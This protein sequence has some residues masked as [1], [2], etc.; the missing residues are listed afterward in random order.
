MDRGVANVHPGQPRQLRRLVVEV[1]VRRQQGDLLQRDQVRVELGDD[2][3]DPRQAVAV[4]VPPPGRR[5][6]LTRTDR[7]PDV[8]CRDP[9][10]RRAAAHPQ[11]CAAT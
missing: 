11:A 9:D 10:G 2:P 3:G 1:A 5:E 8:P 7:G 4:D 6:R